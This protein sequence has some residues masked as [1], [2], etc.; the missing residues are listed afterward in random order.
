MERQ[1]R[2]LSA[3]FLLKS[4][5]LEQRWRAQVCARMTVRLHTSFVKLR[6][7]NVDDAACPNSNR[8]MLQGR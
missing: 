2:Q 4:Q 1:R 7:T 3:D 6:A 5:E 8:G